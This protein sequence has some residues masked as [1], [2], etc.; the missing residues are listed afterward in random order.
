[1]RGA[2]FRGKYDPLERAFAGKGFLASLHHHLCFFFFFFSCPLSQ[3]S[4]PNKNRGG[5][6]T[7]RGGENTRHMSNSPQHQK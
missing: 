1:M 7:K 6:R 4:V 5:E 2:R 3:A